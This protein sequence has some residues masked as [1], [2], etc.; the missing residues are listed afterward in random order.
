MKTRKIVLASLAAVLVAGTALPSFA[1]PGRDGP[2]RQSGRAGMMQE[3]MFVRL[4]K[5]AD[6]NKDAKIT[7]EE[8][9]ARQDALFSEIDA[10]NDGNLIP[11]EL[12]T[13]RDAKMED[14]RKE[15]AERREERRKEMAESR[16]DNDDMHQ[17]LRGER[18]ERRHDGGRWG[19]HHGRMGGQMG[20][21][22]LVRQADTDE[23]GQF[24]KAEVTAAVDKL[25]T[26][27]DRNG[28]GVITIDD[29]PDRPF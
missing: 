9:A 22:H 21:F 10:D 23:N 11:G 25:F 5:T 16:Q 1:G 26:R 2:G 13:Y 6:A 4:L 8:V 27:M 24:S 12:R 18:G 19:M 14:V 20:G 7:K 15:R 17:G 3:M 28:D 29:M